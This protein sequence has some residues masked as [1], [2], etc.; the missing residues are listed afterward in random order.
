M[1]CLVWLPHH[2]DKLGTGNVAIAVTV[3]IGTTTVIVIVVPYNKISNT[4][5]NQLP[6]CLLLLLLF[7]VIAC[8]CCLLMLFVAIVF[9]LCMTLVRPDD[10]GLSVAHLGFEGCECKDE[11]IEG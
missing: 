6:L 3:T 1:V 5:N 9:S 4:C 10:I 7:V 8:C 11:M 2:G